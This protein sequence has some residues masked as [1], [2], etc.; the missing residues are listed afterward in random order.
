MS[1]T[2]PACGETSCNI[3]I[4]LS[5]DGRHAP[6]LPLQPQNDLTASF[7]R[8]SHR[9][10]VDVRVGVARDIFH[11]SSTRLSRFLAN[12]GSS[13]A[14]DLWDVSS[15]EKTLVVRGH[16]GE[17][18]CAWSPP[19]P[20]LPRPFPCRLPFCLPISK[21]DKDCALP[22][23]PLPLQT[24]APPCTCTGHCAPP[25]SVA[26]VQMWAPS[27]RYLQCLSALHSNCLTAHL[28]NLRG[29]QRGRGLTVQGTGCRI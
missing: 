22:A 10:D 19:S 3:A 15:G 24:P 29:S 26:P 11:R 27:T 16:D 5:T 25:T 18:G 17:E 9:P 20:P 28:S 4:A 13:G 14:W 12:A 6:P 1:L 7:H 23:P 8:I 21:P 2:G